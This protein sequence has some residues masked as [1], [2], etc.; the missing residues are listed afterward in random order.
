MNHDMIAAGHPPLRFELASHQ[1]LIER[2]HWDDSPRRFAQPNYEVQ[3]WAA[4]RIAAADAALVLLESRAQRSASQMAPWPEFA[5]SNCFACH[6]PLRP[7]QGSGQ[8]LTSSY[9]SAGFPA[10][11]S[12]N[13]ELIP[14]LLG[15]RAIGENELPPPASLDETLKQ[16]SSN[17][18]SGLKTD[19]VKVVQVASGA[20][21]ALRAQV[22][23]SATG[24]ILGPQGLPLDAD[25]TLSFVQQ[26]LET[27]VE[28]WERLC[29]Q[30]A[31]VV[32]AERSLRD[33]TAAE[34]RNHPFSAQ[35][36]ERVLAAC[37]QVRR[38]IHRVA[39]SLQ[40]TND[41]FEWPAMFGWTSTAAPGETQSADQIAAE[42][43]SL[44]AELR[45]IGSSTEY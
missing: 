45:R 43:E 4:G 29:H 28:T 37:E 19:P 24:E 27:K 13:V 33:R 38:R 6:Q 22:R 35:E 30:L 34:S 25:D 36:R 20:R 14:Q 11:Q 39:R 18:G 5:E 17:M 40:F 31:A 32:A 21:A 2:K 41:R 1:A 12:W 15:P 10:W 8:T 9:G 7:R 3:L 44:V 42:M 23:V 26:S 16:I